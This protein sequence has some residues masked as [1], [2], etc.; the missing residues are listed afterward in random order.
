MYSVPK[1]EDYSPAALH[2]AAAE[3]LAALEAESQA[4]S[5]AKAYEDFRN[6]WMSR[7][8]GIL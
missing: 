5:D 8:N 6:R 7:K 2:A 3:L 1:L 4:A